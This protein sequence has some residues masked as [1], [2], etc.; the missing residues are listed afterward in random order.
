MAGKM[1][2]KEFLEALGAGLLLPAAAGAEAPSADASPKEVYL[3]PLAHY[4]L[5]WTGTTPECLSRAYRILTEAI[6]KCEA[7]PTGF[8][9]FVD[10]LFY[11]ERYLSTHPEKLAVCKEL[12]KRGQLEINP[13]WI[14]SFQDD[15]PGE[16]YVRYFLYPKMFLRET[17]GVDPVAVCLTDLPEW[18]PQFPQIAA[19]CGIKFVVRVRCGPRDSRLFWWQAPDA[20]KVLTAFYPGEQ[21]GTVFTF[22]LPQMRN[23]PSRA[24]GAMDKFINESAGLTRSNYLLAGFG[25]DRTLPYKD[26]ER[27]VAEWNKISEDKIRLS[28]L[29]EYYD[30]VKDTPGLAVY[31][32]EVPNTWPGIEAGFALSFQDAQKA[33]NLLLTAEKLATVSNLLGVISY[34][35][36]KIALAWKSLALAHDHGYGGHGYEE[37][38]RR[39]I[40]ERQKAI[41]AA[42]EII[43]QS[44]APIAERVSTDDVDC[45][46][47]VVFNPL[48]WKRNEIV[49]AHF[50]LQLD[51]N[52]ESQMDT[53]PV[54]ARRK[55]KM[56][57]RDDQGRQV[58]F[59]VVKNN[60]P[61]EYYIAFPGE[62][63][64]PLGYRTYY[65]Y[66]S[67]EEEQIET[68][69]R[70]GEASLEN[71]FVRVTVNRENGAVALLD[72]AAGEP[73]SEGVRLSVIEDLRPILS[74]KQLE[75]LPEAPV[76]LRK[77]IVEERGPIRAA[78]RLIYDCDLAGLRDIELRVSLARGQRNVGLENTLGYKM[79]P[80]EQMSGVFQVFPMRTQAPEIRYGI[81]YGD[82]GMDGLLPNSGF[83][84]GYV[85][86]TYLPLHFWKRTRLVQRWLD[87]G[88]KGRGTTIASSRQLFIVSDADARCCLLQLNPGAFY[89]CK[90]IH[91]GSVVSRFSIT[92]RAGTWQESKTYRTGWELT[93]PLL[94]YSVNDTVTKKTLPKSLSFLG[95]ASDHAVVTVL[96]KA[97]KGE[98]L[99]VRFFEA[100]GRDGTA[101]LEFFRPIREAWSCNL[102]EEKEKRVEL[103]NVPLSKREIKTL[104]LSV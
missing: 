56:V 1:S 60:P 53:Y 94:A 3:F 85:E 30:K 67:T 23:Q 48:S 33:S 70:V 37:G 34:P 27:D 35:Q 71:E 24:K 87:A 9:Y 19:R 41:Y 39:K 68:N 64:P 21:F 29:T 6:E 63:I 54:S 83:L 61:L 31:S 36:E 93:N 82:N 104:R 100:E 84:G 32:G 92:P 98:G 28:T 69:L 89:L 91:Q 20:T 4:D 51:V 55:Q 44:L 12:V 58:P 75:E 57:L 40:E 11:F 86:R 65:L 102:L 17:F 74:G 73:I 101:Q 13:L 95:P 81:P 45:I 42:E 66:P 97:E 25:T 10:N 38:D 14:I 22:A 103:R 8:R 90:A 7:N 18:S 88:E 46:P 26:L 96:K 99:V 43:E 62:D 77:I 49:D 16:N 76:R 2:R 79:Q 50:T 47:I 5:A 59:Q 78:L 80:G 72:K 52:R 15:H